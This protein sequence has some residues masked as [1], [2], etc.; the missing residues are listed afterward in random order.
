MAEGQYN[1]TQDL[2]LKGKGTDI[3]IGGNLKQYVLNSQGTLFADTTGHILIN[4]GGAYLQASQKFL[5]DVLKLTG[6]IRYDKNENF[7]GH[8]TPRFSAV[9]TVAKDQNIRLSY[10][11]A[12]RFPTTQNQ[13]I[14]LSVGNNEKLIG[15]LPQFR[16]YYNFSGNPVY[17]QASFEQFAATG[18]P[19]LLQ[20]QTFNP[21][22]PESSNSFEV[23][24]K[25]L[26]AQR[27][28]VD[29]YAYYAVY[30]NFLTRENVVQS[31]DGTPA[32]L[33]NPN[34]YSISVNSQ[35]N[36]FTSGLG[37]S[38]QYLLRNNYFITGNVYTDQL[39]NPPSNLLT[40]YRAN[41]G[42]GNSGFLYKN[43]IGFNV[44]WRWQDAYYNQSDFISGNTGAFSTIDAQVSY[45]LPKIKSIIKLGAT[46]L[47]NAYYV[48]AYGNPYVGGLY[49]ISYGF[50]V[51]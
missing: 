37:L 44:I 40:K 24:Y 43:R 45:K 31:A 5:H 15:G 7:T 9:I 11:T 39:N 16:T 18:N 22:K 17:T 2:G 46:N 14:N 13:W 30:K 48:N 47:L 1:L 10:Q 20:V 50:N 19:A 42:F 28:L 36:L 32:G 26:F 35:T 3:L 6:S 33:A 38:I 4:E 41:I 8:A 51:Y 27:F 29:V 23:G 25:G 21:Y 49:Y 12:Y 34:I